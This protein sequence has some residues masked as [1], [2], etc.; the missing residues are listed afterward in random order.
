MK[1]LLIF[2]TCY[3]HWRL[4]QLIA[5]ATSA[6]PSTARRASSTLLPT[7]PGV[8]VGHSTIIED[9][10]NGSAARSGVTAVL[11]RGEDSIVSARLRWFRS[12]ERR[13]RDDRHDLA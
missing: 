13:R 11:P 9:Y 1:S 7:C 4:V 8:T 10:P 12:P 6:F 3:F 2:V 5:L